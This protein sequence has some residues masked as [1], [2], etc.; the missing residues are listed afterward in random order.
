MIMDKVFGKTQKLKFV[1]SLITV[2][3]CC[4][5]TENNFSLLIIE[6]DVISNAKMN[7]SDYFENF[8]ML[9]L[10]TDSV[11]GEI[12]K[13]QYENDR[14]YISDSQ[15]T[16]FIFSDN[17]ELLF[18]FNKKGQGPGEYAGITDFAV[19]GDV[20]TILSQRKL[21]SYNQFGEYISI[22]NLEFDVQSISILND[23][24]FLYSGSM[25]QDSILYK[26]HIVRNRQ[27]NERFLPI[28]EYRSKYLF[29][30]RT[31][32][33]Y[34]HQDLIYF[35]E[36]FNDTVYVS[37]NNEISPFFY[38][39]YKG[40]NIPASF[41]K[42]GFSDIAEFYTE[43]N[44]TS[45]TYGTFNF[46]LY[47]QFLMFGS[48]YQGNRILTVFD[49][50]KQIS[51]TFTAI[52]DDVYFKDLTIPTSEFNYYAE[53]HILVP[54]NAFKV[55]EWRKTFQSEKQFKELVDATDE[56]DNPLILIF[57]FKQ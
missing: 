6:A 44:K 53:K 50:K 36:P 13:I 21:L 27:E 49:R 3:C 11:M 31:Q 54:I 45:Y 26:L 55:V 10:P 52:K 7:L 37:N 46:A 9:K 22:R 42:R 20:I 34:R 15:H 16:M 19:N 24:Y 40:K 32:N 33:F 39:D 18:C 56:E 1:V 17:G 23:A 38:I 41:F 51:H 57:D 30:W 48:Y 14:I 2:L 4:Q 25:Y 28:D 29:I 12:R 47:D 8:R 5:S 35:F 43:Y